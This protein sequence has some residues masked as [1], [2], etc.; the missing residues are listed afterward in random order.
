M[1]GVK[2][3]PNLNSRRRMLRRRRWSMQKCGVAP[4][5]VAQNFKSDYYYC[6][7]SS[8]IPSHCISKLKLK[9]GIFNFCIPVY[10]GKW[11]HWD[12][13]WDQLGFNICLDHKSTIFNKP[14]GRAFWQASHFFL[15][16]QVFSEAYLNLL[17]NIKP[18]CAHIYTLFYLS[19]LLFQS[20]A[21]LEKQKE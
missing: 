3:F 9:E 17:S 19:D 12:S 18:L 2:S 7:Y 13:I 20:R 11:Q 5:C 14:T 8:C 10:I 21:L 6:F 16:S 4:S 1:L 15:R